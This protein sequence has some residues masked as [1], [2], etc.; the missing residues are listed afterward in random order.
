[1]TKIPVKHP[2]I[3]Q[4]FI[5]IQMQYPDAIVAVEVGDFFEIWET[6]D[7]IGFAK[8]A[9]MLADITLTRKNN[10]K[11][12]SPYMAGFPAR[13]AEAYFKKLVDAKQTVVVVE[14]TIRGAKEDNN[15]QVTRAV[16]KVL[17][18]GTL[19]EKN[20]V[21]NN[22]F[23]S[24]YSEDDLFVGITLID[25]GTG[26]VKVTEVSKNDLM[27][28]LEKYDPKEIL[29]TGKL[30]FDFKS[31]QLVH[32]N[33]DKKSVNKLAA[34]GVLLGKIYNLEAFAGNSFQ[35]I[36]SLG[37]D[38]WRYGTLAFCN[39]IN[40][41][42]HTEYNALLLKK[43]SEPETLLLNNQ[44]FIPMNGYNSLDIFE[45]S[46]NPDKD[47]TLYGVLDECQTFMGKRLLKDWLIAPLVELNSINYRHNKVEE[48]QSKET[49]SLK[50]VYDIQRISRRMIFSKLNPNEIYFLH[51]SL[52]IASH[53]FIQEKDD[54]TV[55]KIN[56]ILKKIEG[57][58][59]LDLASKYTDS[60]EYSFLKGP[61]KE[62]IKDSFD[63]FNE[64]LTELNLYRKELELSLETDKIRFEEK[65]KSIIM[66]APKG[67][68]AKL[69]AFGIS[70]EVK[71]SVLTLRS[72]KIDQ[73]CNNFFAAKQRFLNLAKK[74]FELFQK[75]LN[76]E[77]GVDLFH[78]AKGI[79]QYD[80]LT[81]FAKI[82]TER[83][84]YRPTIIDSK[85]AFVDLKDLRHPIVENSKSLH[86]EFV[87]NDMQLG[88]DLKTLIIYGAN[89][90][91]KS[92]ILKSTAIAII[93]NQIGCF[94]PAN[95][96]SSLSIFEAI[97]TRMSSID[98][99]AEGLST[100]VMECN[101]LNQALRYMNKKS[102]FLFDEIGRGTSVNDGEALAYAT[103]GFLDTED[104][105]SISLFATHYHGLYDNIKELKSVKVMHVHCDLDHNE[106]IIF[107]RKL[108]DGP[109][110]GSYGILVAKSC[111]LPRQLI[112]IAENYNKIYFPIKQSRYN[113][114]I[115]GTI[116]PNCK[117]NPVQ[118][119]HH[120]VEQ[121][122]GKVKMIE[123]KNGV[124]KSIHHSSNLQMLCA[125]C[126]DKL[127]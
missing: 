27:D 21:K 9:A 48:Y 55:I 76:D 61:I 25:V 56:K 59:D 108:Q 60:D 58:I 89:S 26:N 91:G 116:C 24:L 118:E 45:T 62:K 7:G 126:H 46:F 14:Q 19:F 54:E 49:I 34:A 4:F 121:K 123:S 50:D 2:P 53:I 84:Y 28:F 103:V 111:G 100:F 11:E 16:T 10:S 90:A 122:Q 93:M 42:I 33:S 73:M 82:S 20:S 65:E 43:L 35:P 13:S 88:D 115:F 15:K 39:V 51:N 98:N 17:S 71:A 18:P 77:F 124:K 30:N 47:K 32:V 110:D 112:K 8:K 68:K 79:A 117:E 23:A 127:G 81:T 41:W 97:L 92:T 5:D 75:D 85:K 3:I 74:E 63:K 22:Y 104:N 96:G 40:F 67:V 120:L 12:D 72:T 78:I 95:N 37:L 113:S 105:I 36:V 83:G 114:K 64:S 94:I 44:L 31:S 86:T 52:K 101:E 109:G 1:M 102:L 70:C 6:V 87:S 106:N 69:G 80:V 66:V 29:I 119:T 107:I 57:S 125:A 99:L 38:K